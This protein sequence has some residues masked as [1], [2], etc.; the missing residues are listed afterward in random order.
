[1]IDKS[2]LLVTAAISFVFTTAI[3]ATQYYRKQQPQSKKEKKAQKEQNVEKVE[4]AEADGSEAAVKQNLAIIQKATVIENHIPTL[5]SHIE[6]QN[7]LKHKE[8]SPQVEAELAA[9]EI[10]PSL[11]KKKPAI[12]TTIQEEP[13]DD[14]EEK[15]EKIDDKS[16][17]KPEEK[18]EEKLEEKEEKPS[19]Y[20]EKVSVEDYEK[21]KLIGRG[22]FGEVYLVKKKETGDIFALKQLRKSSVIKQDQAAH[23]RAERDIM[24]EA[25][26]LDNEWVVT[27][28]CSFQDAIYLYL[29]MEYLPGGDLLSLMIKHETFNED[30]VRFFL[31]EIVLAVESVHKLGYVHRDIKPDNVL[32]G[33][34]GHIKLSDFGLCTGFRP[35]H[36]TKMYKNHVGDISKE[37]SKHTHNYKMQSWTKKN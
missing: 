16:E 17:E 29:L 12:Q 13:E 14:K 22:A 26:A 19:I 34:D 20:S 35:T 30:Q 37:I 5:A 36:D 31:A 21:L 10:N 28:Y 27:L 24:A 32:I 7:V 23:A 9:N 4:K 18:P 6:E 11:N 1:M 8:V 3:F 25:E 33:A 15:L 2:V